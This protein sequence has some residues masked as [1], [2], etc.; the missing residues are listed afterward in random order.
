MQRAV[1]KNGFFLEE[2]GSWTSPAP[3]FGGEESLVPIMS[4]SKTIRN[5]D[6]LGI[7]YDEDQTMLVITDT[8]LWH[9]KSEKAY[10]VSSSAP[11]YS[12]EGSLLIHRHSPTSAWIPDRHGHEYSPRQPLPAIPARPSPPALQSVASLPSSTDA[13]HVYRC[14][15]PCSNDENG[16]QGSQGVGFR[17]LVVGTSGPVR[18]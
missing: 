17:C 7:P 3:R 15:R 13:A 10:W 16:G 12:A 8:K 18:P 4:K 5:S 2:K 14:L 1:L 6:I 11:L 9:E